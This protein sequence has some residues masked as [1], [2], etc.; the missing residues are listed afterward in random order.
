MQLPN[1][2]I[3]LT[4]LALAQAYPFSSPLATNSNTSTTIPVLP[5]RESQP[6]IGFAHSCADKLV[7]D[8]YKYSRPS[9]SEAAYGND[10][11]KCTVF[12][13]YPGYGAVFI[14]W[15]KT[16]VRQVEIHGKGDC[17][18][19][20]LGVLVRKEGV[21]DPQCYTQ[22]DSGV[23]LEVW[24]GDWKGVSREGGL[25]VHQQRSSLSHPV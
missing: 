10:G 2:L 21:R 13:R 12:H 8:D 25:H 6:W 11:F 3:L 19:K 16:K 5:R 24:N 9:L 4:T 17:T 23:S 20:V 15:G 1:T 18:D 7:L 22:E 14:N